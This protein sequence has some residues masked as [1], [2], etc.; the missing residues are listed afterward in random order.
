MNWPENKGQFKNRTLLL[1]LLQR[2]TTGVTV[3]N[4]WQKQGVQKKLGAGEMDTAR[5][6][7]DKMGMMALE[8]AILQYTP[9]GVRNHQ[10][11]ISPIILSLACTFQCFKT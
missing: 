1:Q 9:T 5:Q 8:K 3:Q 6:N 4:N 7:S 11:L 2:V 10:G